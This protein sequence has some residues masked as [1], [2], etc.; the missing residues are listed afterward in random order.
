MSDMP[1]SLYH[2]RGLLI[3]TQLIDGKF[4]LNHMVKVEL[5]VKLLLFPFHALFLRP[6]TLRRGLSFTCWREVSYRIC[7][8]MVKASQ[9]LANLRE[10]F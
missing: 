10:V 1:F 5:P 6:Y 8:H 2:I 7:T 4:N 3:Y 9:L